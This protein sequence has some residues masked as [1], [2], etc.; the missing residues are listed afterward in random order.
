MTDGLDVRLKGI[1]LNRALATAMNEIKDSIGP[2]AWYQHLVYGLARETQTNWVEL[3][4]ADNEQQITRL[5]WAARNLLELYYWTRYV[6]RSPEDARRVFEDLLCD[7]QDVLKWLNKLPGLEVLTQEKAEELHKMREQAEHVEDETKFLTGAK[8]AR[9]FN[10]EF[11]FGISNKMLSK[12]VHPTILMTQVRAHADTPE[13]L[14]IRALI[15]EAGVS[16]ALWLFPALTAE[17]N[18]I[19]PGTVNV[20]ATSSPPPLKLR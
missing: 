11:E 13:V 9:L 4:E 12:F 10:E 8:I 5:A 6:L 15:L 19:N 16:Y 1:E 18:R 20:P 14:T 3:V 7:F 2:N 17:L